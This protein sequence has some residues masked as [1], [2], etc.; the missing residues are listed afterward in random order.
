MGSAK[1]GV[2]VVIAR[3]QENTS[4]WAFTGSSGFDQ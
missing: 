1:T 2:E 3:V 4:R